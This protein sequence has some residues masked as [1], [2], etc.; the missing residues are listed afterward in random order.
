MFIC[1]VAQVE[2]LWFSRQQGHQLAWQQHVEQ[3]LLQLEQQAAQGQTASQ[4]AAVK[5][6]MSQL[7]AQVDAAP[8]HST[9]GSLRAHGE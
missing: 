8:T 1:V 4:L 3:Q 9:M 5:E 6:A 2:G 7:Q